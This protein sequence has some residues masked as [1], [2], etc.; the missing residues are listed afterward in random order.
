MGELLPL[1]W[2]DGGSTVVLN[3]RKISISPSA[4]RAR[5]APITILLVWGIYRK[6]ISCSNQ[7]DLLS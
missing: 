1:I 3:C 5:A 6:R 2:L 7:Q 4:K